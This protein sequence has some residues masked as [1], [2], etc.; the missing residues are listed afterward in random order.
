MIAINHCVM[1]DFHYR[2]LPGDSLL[3]FIYR[4]FPVGS[5]RC[6]HCDQ[7]YEGI[8]ERELFG[9]F[10]GARSPRGRPLLSILAR[11]LSAVA[12]S[13]AFVVYF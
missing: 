3:L 1:L 2:W 5:V 6:W 9:D 13:F 10:I 4:W 7:L 11:Q 8:I 12:Y